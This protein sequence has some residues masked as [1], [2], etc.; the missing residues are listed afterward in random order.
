MAQALTL[1]NEIKL[2]SYADLTDAVGSET[3]TY[4]LQI[5]RYFICLLNNGSYKQNS[6]SKLLANVSP[7][8]P[9]ILGATFSLLVTFSTRDRHRGKVEKS[10]KKPSLVRGLKEEMKTIATAKIPNYRASFDF[11]HSKRMATEY[12]YYCIRYRI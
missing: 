2:I 9:K 6:T 7:Q 3:E 12:I 4:S 10:K 8:N 11:G 1:Q 5:D